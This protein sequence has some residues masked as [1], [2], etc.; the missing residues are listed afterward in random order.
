MSKILHTTMLLEGPP[1]EVV[2]AEPR[3]GYEALQIG[4]SLTVLL[5]RAPTETLLAVAAA[6]TQAAENRAP[7]A[8]AA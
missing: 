8:V 4:T 5:D 3:C 7:R 1:N 2:L 6:L